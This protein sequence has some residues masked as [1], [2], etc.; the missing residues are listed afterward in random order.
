MVEFYCFW[1]MKIKNLN[2]GYSQKRKSKLQETYEK[3]LKI[4]SHQENAKDLNELP[5]D[6]HQLVTDTDTSYLRLSI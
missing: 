5:P 6:T 2:R 3:G 4:F 1:F